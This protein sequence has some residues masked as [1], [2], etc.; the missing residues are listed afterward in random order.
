MSIATTLQSIRTNLSA[1][2]TA[3]TNKGA[4]IPANKNIENLAT[5]I[6]SIPSGGTSKL[7]AVVDRSVTTITA[8]DLDG[9]TSIGYWAFAKCNELTSVE[10]PDSVLSLKDGCFRECNGL[11]SIVIPNSVTSTEGNLFYRCDYLSSITLSNSLTRIADSMFQNCRGLT[12]IVVPD[13]VTYLGSYSFSL[14]NSLTIVKI[15]NG[16]RTIS[17]G[18]FNGCSS[19]IDV[20]IART[21]PPTLYYSSAFDNANNCTISVPYN[22]VKAY[23]TA[24]NWSSLLSRIQGFAPSGTFSQGDTLPTTSTEGLTLTWYSDVGRTQQVTTVS[25]PTAE[26]YCTAVSEVNYDKN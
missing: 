14:C 12:S 13:G 9:A 25:D 2:W 18:V 7:Q 4:T 24:T 8:Q 19:L 6:T 3:L 17:S 15:G 23:R 21:S 11:T 10:I 1:A 26:Y 22:N 5:A 16:L 20:S